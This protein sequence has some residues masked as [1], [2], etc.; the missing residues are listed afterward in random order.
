LVASLGSFCIL[1]GIRNNLVD[2]LVEDHDRVDGFQ[3]V[4]RVEHTEVEDVAK[5][6]NSREDLAQLESH[7][8]SED[9]DNG[10]DNNTCIEVDGA[11]NLLDVHIPSENLHLLGSHSVDLSDKRGFLQRNL[12]LANASDDISNE[13]NPPVRGLAV[14]KLE[15]GEFLVRI[16]LQQEQASHHEVAEDDH[17]A[18]ETQQDYRTQ[19]GVQGDYDQIREA[20]RSI[21]EHLDVFRQDVDDLS[22]SFLELVLVLLSFR[23]SHNFCSILSRRANF[24][25]Q[26]QTLNFFKNPSLNSRLHVAE[27]VVD[28]EVVVVTD[29]Q[30]DGSE[31]V[32]REEEPVV[33]SI[34][35]LLL[36]MQ[37]INDKP[38][39]INGGYGAHLD[40]GQLSSILY[41][42][43]HSQLPDCLL[44]AQALLLHSRSPLGVQVLGLLFLAQEVKMLL[45][46]FGLVLEVVNEGAQP[47]H[48]PV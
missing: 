40:R 33:V 21:G 37:V 10:R 19:Q 41:H 4:V 8:V 11:A 34:D 15:R 25:P 2:P 35:W 45:L 46:H 28:V 20:P 6:G 48:H 26:P 47:C 5:Q 12:D 13:S 32:E 24:M 14:V 1:L 39:R 17:W 38:N 9:E 18:E 22:F 16:V 27:V 23:V 31:E 36:V 44:Y 43:A 29:E 7:R 30:R 3:G 42:S